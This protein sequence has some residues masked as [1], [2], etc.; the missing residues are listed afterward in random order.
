MMHDIFLNELGLICALGKGQQ[1]VRAALLAPEA[2]STIAALH[3]ATGVE[4]PTAPV[5]AALADI[6]GLPLAQ[7][8]RNNALLLTALEQIREPVEAAIDRYGPSRVAV[9]LGTSTSGIGESERAF[10]WRKQHGHFPQ[11]FHPSQ[12]ELGSPAE[13]LASVLGTSGVATVISTACSSSAKALASAA[14]MLQAGFCDAVICGGADS[15]CDFTVAGFA[16]LESVSPQGCNPMSRNRNGIHI[17]EAAALF[18]MSR[19]PGPVALCGYG[20]TSDAYHISAP[21]PSGQGACSAMQ[22]ALQMAGLAPA[23]IDYINLHGT[24]TRQNDAMEAAA[25]AK[26][27][28][29]QTPAS[30]TKPL[31]GHTLGAAGALEAAFAWLTLEGNPA[32]RLPPHH[33]D[34]ANDPELPAL[35]LVPPEF[36][37]STAPRYIISNSFAFGGSNIALILGKSAC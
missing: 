9:V 13:M 37:L 8:S 28:G 35:T 23:D 15:L 26:L 36:S 5:K 34:G 2:A 22:L 1:D 25:V 7:Q 30:S 24:A 11:D 6:S 12:Q 4:Y 32:H 3:L 29:L 14:R 31:T 21:D 33:W 19:T 18:L 10:A 27:F 17:G 20:E 16:A